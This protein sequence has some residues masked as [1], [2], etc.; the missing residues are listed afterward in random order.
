MKAVSSD[1][2]ERSET[3][4]VMPSIDTLRGVLDSVGAAFSCD[5][6]DGIHVASDASTVD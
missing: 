3:A 1:I 6:A 5:G 2:S 4:A